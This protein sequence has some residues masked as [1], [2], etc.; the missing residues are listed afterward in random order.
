M[1]KTTSSVRAH[2]PGK[3]TW[4]RIYG[5]I[6]SPCSSIIAGLR[7]G[8]GFMVV[9]A[10][11]IS[12]DSPMQPHIGEVATYAHGPL[13]WSLR[14]YGA[15]GKG[16]WRPEQTY[17][18]VLPTIWPWAPLYN[19]TVLP[20]KGSVWCHMWEIFSSRTKNG[21]QAPCTTKG[22]QLPLLQGWVH[23]ALMW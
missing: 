19:A 21:I 13:Q 1:Y 15:I 16:G 18:C 8:G 4:R 23:A 9:G 10:L 3:D 7:W 17:P 12:P 6:L 22:T 20:S 14:D 2:A 11:F 5:S